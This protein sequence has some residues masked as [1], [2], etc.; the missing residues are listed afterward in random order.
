MP[1]VT[2]ISYD[3]F[4]SYS[5]ADST[6]ANQVQQFL[7]GY[8]HPRGI[9]SGSTLR[10]KVFRD[11]TDQALSA[12]FAAV[13]KERICQCPSF[14]LLGSEAA[15]V[16]PHVAME[17]EFFLQTGRDS[18]N[19]ALIGKTAE[20]SFP[21]SVRARFP[22]AIYADLRPPSGLGFVRGQ[23]SKR[24]RFREEMLRIAAGILQRKAGVSL[25]YEALRL[26]ER[27]RF[28]RR[29]AFSIA[30]A[31]LAGIALTFYYASTEA[32]G[33]HWTDMG[34]STVEEVV[35]L[36]QPE[37]DIQLFAIKKDRKKWIGNEDGHAGT[38][39]A[40]EING[41]DRK[42]R[43]RGSLAFTFLGE[44]DKI[45]KLK[46][47]GVFQDMDT[48][49]IS[50]ILSRFGYS[51]PEGETESLKTAAAAPFPWKTDCDVH[52]ASQ[53]VSHLF[54]S[55]RAI[56]ICGN[57]HTPP[58]VAYS[59][60]DAGVTWSR[61]A[62][63]PFHMKLVSLW[64]SNFPPGVSF[65]G[66]PEFVD[67][68]YG[69]K[70]GLFVTRNFGQ[71]WEVVP[72]T[73]VSGNW[74][75]LSTVGGN[76]MDSQLFAVAMN[77]SETTG[78][79]RTAGIWLTRNG[80]TNWEAVGFQG[81]AISI[82]SLNVSGQGDVFAIANNQLIIYRKRSVLDRLLQRFDLPLSGKP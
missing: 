14:L 77:V 9:F 8:R 73:P 40:V 27:Q 79:A 21:Q 1:P 52:Q 25:T 5:S 78:D 81:G 46:R 45:T 58:V 2:E 13:F 12:D 44:W 72:V 59:T 17:C 28:V 75:S 50:E 19:L 49:S 18:I 30:A 64:A 48:N 55:K 39:F 23:F 69:T 67:P 74:N 82:S 24:T 51:S 57:D 3:V 76:T 41:L 42:G 6:I 71:S 62:E 61:S 11:K 10:I 70:G 63:F 33:V 68:Y 66:T 37:R 20:G 29:T 31:V 60:T 32:R 54:D 35:F 7:E 53:S 15:C 80:G 26:R 43:S 16:S 4:L 34:R 36:P 65:I 56:Q 47:S 38:D 22:R